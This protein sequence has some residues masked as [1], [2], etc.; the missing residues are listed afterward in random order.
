MIWLFT[1]KDFL[2]VCLSK[3]TFIIMDEI[4]AL[5]EVT[6]RV[7]VSPFISLLQSHRLEED[8][9]K[10][11]LSGFTAWKICTGEI[12]L[13]A[14]SYTSPST[15]VVL[16]HTSKGCMVALFLQ[17][18][19]VKILRL[20]KPGFWE[21]LAPHWDLNFVAQAYFQLSCKQFQN[22][23]LRFR[24]ICNKAVIRYDVMCN[25]NKNI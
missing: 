1:G 23:I 12:Y 9:I 7:W 25:N 4:R 2:S 14:Y 8:K 3:V 20:N 13:N 10:G 15:V 5:L 19:Y 18:D 21:S 16:S 6:G 22:L 11:S 17:E 24:K